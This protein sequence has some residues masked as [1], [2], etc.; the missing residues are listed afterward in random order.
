MNIMK[1]NSFSIALALLAAILISACAQVSPQT[2]TPM[3]TPD[4]LPS[5]GREQDRI[6]DR[7]IVIDRRYMSSLRER[8]LAI[9]SGGVA[10][11]NYHLNKADAW[12]DFATEEYANNDRSGIVE[13][14]LE[15]SVEL[16]RG[17]E[18]KQKNLSMNTPILVGSRKI[19]DDLWQRAQRFKSHDGFRCVEG[20]VARLEVQLVWAGHEEQDG[21]W[22]NARPYIEIAEEMAERIELGLNRCESA[23][24]RIAEAI[25]PP[26]AAASIPPVAAIAREPIPAGLPP[27]EPVQSRIAL[28]ADA[29]FR[30]GGAA[31]ADLLPEGLVRIDALIERLKAGGTSGRILITG[32][33]DRLGDSSFNLKLSEQRAQVLRTLL[34]ERGFEADRVQ[35]AGAGESEP[36]VTC[37][38]DRA[39]SALIDCLQP[40]RRVEVRV[41]AVP[42][43]GSGP[44]SGPGLSPSPGPSSTPSPSPSP[45]PSSSPLNQS[46]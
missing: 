27:A 29:L 11:N 1:K 34:I 37:S 41:L 33:T 21:G 39:S 46:R 10:A 7:A 19:R 18:A 30:F 23:K 40:N 38:G 43:A 12:L 28:S 26:A 2:P 22:R 20:S 24:T 9:N 31:R 3:S 35:A 44:A 15:Q 45:S 5:A 42:G 16:I 8:M 6:S 36:I 14:V 32:H 4:Q 17:L 13:R 25:E